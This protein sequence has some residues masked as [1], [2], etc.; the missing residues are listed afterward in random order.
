MEPA[1][2]ITS[3]LP[4]E[5]MCIDGAIEKDPNLRESLVPPS[6]F[7]VILFRKLFVGLVSKIGTNRPKNEKPEGRNS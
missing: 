3:F 5:K 4:E 6:D 2:A 1:R 7:F